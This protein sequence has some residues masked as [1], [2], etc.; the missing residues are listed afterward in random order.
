MHRYLLGLQSLTD[1]E[2]MSQCLMEYTASS[3]ELR[4]P[5]IQG[6]SR[7]RSTKSLVAGCLQLFPGLE[8]GLVLV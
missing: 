8:P 2:M 5:L 3:A 6:Q 4:S 7:A 1:K